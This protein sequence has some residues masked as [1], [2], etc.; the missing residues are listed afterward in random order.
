MTKFYR[1]SESGTEELVLTP[2]GTD[3]QVEA[4]AAVI[5]TALGA[6]D[7]RAHIIARAALAAAQAV[8]TSIVCPACKGER[9]LG[10]RLCPTCKGTAMVAAQAVAPAPDF[11]KIGLAITSALSWHPSENGPSYRERRDEVEILIREA[12][13]FTPAPWPMEEQVA[14]EIATQSGYNP[15]E[16]Y[17]QQ[18]IWQ[19]F[20]R[21]AR[22]VDALYRTALFPK[23]Q[24]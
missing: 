17:K 3:E 7:Y 6:G 2:R 23:V 21:H 19:M 24:I 1:S 15:K 16:R 8:P 11:V 13:A 20:S 4:A 10:G 22:A 18:Q 9:R 5:K 14:S 12:L